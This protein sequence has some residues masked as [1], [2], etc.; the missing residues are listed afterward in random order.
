MK[1]IVDDNDDNDENAILD[2]ISKIAVVGLKFQLINID[3]SS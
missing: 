2:S 3:S 1:H